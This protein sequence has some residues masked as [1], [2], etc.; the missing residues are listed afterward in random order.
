MSQVDQVGDIQ[1]EVFELS[2]KR[3]L[4]GLAVTAA[5]SLVMLTFLILAAETS[6]SLIFGFS[7][8]VIIGARVIALHYFGKANVEETATSSKHRLSVIT[9]IAGASDLLVVCLGNYLILVS[10]AASTYPLNLVCIAAAASY[11]YIYLFQPVIGS[12]MASII[13]LVPAFLAPQTVVTNTIGVMAA[14]IPVVALIIVSSVHLRK[15]FLSS[16]ERVITANLHHKSQSEKNEIYNQQWE[17]T[18]LAAIGWD[19]GYKIRSWNPS[20]EKAFGYTAD[21]ALGK[22]LNLLLSE[23]D[24]TAI[25]RNWRRLWQTQMGIRTELL[26][27]KKNGE[28]VYT[29]WHDSVVMKNGS[30]IGF[31]SFIE[32]VTSQVKANEI[33]KNQAEYDSL[34]GLPNRRFLMNEIEKAINNS[35]STKEYAALIFIDLDNFKDIND[36]E[37]HHVGDYV[38]RTFA[39]KVKERLRKEDVFARFG[40]DEFVVLL[41]KM[42]KSRRKAE[43]S[44]K[45]IIEEILKVGKEVCNI[46]GN[47]YHIEFSGGAVL[48]EGKSEDPFE[49]LKFADQAMYQVKNNGRNDIRFFDEAISIETEYRIELLRGLRSGVDNN[50]FELF[51]QPIVN[52]KGRITFVE[53]LLRWQKDNKATV[54]AAEFIDVMHNSPVITKV[55]YWTFDRS[56]EQIKSLI[57]GNLWEDD[58][59]F[60]INVSPK[61]LK[62]GLFSTRLLTILDEN[63]IKPEWVVIEI[64][65]DSLIQNYAEVLDQLKNLLKHG[66]RI[67]LD[68]FG[69]GF[70]SLALLKDLPVHFLKLDKEFTHTL[71]ESPNHQSIV[72]AIIKLCSVLSIKTIAEAVETKEQFETLKK[73]GCDYFQGYYFQEPRPLSE[74]MTT[75]DKKPNLQ[76]VQEIA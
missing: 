3:L 41:E 72:Q 1:Q 53:N 18:P 19:R 14:C 11:A 54:N 13:A 65:E 26:A 27:K 20:A 33:I 24:S 37:G 36:T 47:T 51:C 69:T 28:K 23:D 60:F 74:F 76:I 42:G 22:S 34:T 8:V 55:G 70:S 6:L 40:G 31:S 15:I 62:D 66:I 67:A 48:F 7:A 32:D 39:S 49:I 71:N 46:C 75:L 25:K 5:F 43:T 21:E 2:S 63:N 44:V 50:E 12:V 68:D 29:E 58:F 52:T 38:L 4:V 16:L 56:C 9:S 59:A 10:D 64:T 30:P 61:Q 35:K 57:E 17:N 45:R 73:M